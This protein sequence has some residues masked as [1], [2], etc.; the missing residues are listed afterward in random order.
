MPLV[1]GNGW[2]Y[3]NPQLGA[4]QMRPARRKPIALCLY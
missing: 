1:F 3:M 4:L 2:A